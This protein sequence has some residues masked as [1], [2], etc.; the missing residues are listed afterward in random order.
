MVCNVLG[1]PKI[2]AITAAKQLPKIDIPI[3]IGLTG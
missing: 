3:R 1:K 2:K